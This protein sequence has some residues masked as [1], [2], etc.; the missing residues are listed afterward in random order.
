MSPD[1]A[2]KMC[3]KVVV[4]RCEEGGVFVVG[5]AGAPCVRRTLQRQ[6]QGHLTYDVHTRRPWGEGLTNNITL[7]M[8]YEDGSCTG[9]SRN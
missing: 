8:S 7:R 1:R 4:E 2:S 5:R 3:T 9:S 6:E